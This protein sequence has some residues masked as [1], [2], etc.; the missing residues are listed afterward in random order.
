MEKVSWSHSFWRYKSPRHLN[1]TALQN[2]LELRPIYGIFCLVMFP[3]P[4]Q[5]IYNFELHWLFCYLRYFSYFEIKQR[6]L[7]KLYSKS[8]ENWCQVHRSK[9]LHS[10]KFTLF[11]PIFLQTLISD[12][13]KKSLV[14]NKK[15][16]HY[17]SWRA[18]FI[19]HRNKHS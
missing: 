16:E 2:L 3:R 11:S 7:E 13:S 12:Y 8:V 14:K 6:K 10:A 19:S 17:H 18:K 5:I 15:G 1:V 4:I 9:F